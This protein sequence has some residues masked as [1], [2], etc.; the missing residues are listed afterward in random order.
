MNAQRFE[1]ARLTVAVGR[2]LI[3]FAV[4][5][6]SQAPMGAQP[7]HGSP[8]PRPSDALIRIAPRFGSAAAFSEG[9]AA[10]SVGDEKHAKWGFIDR[11]G[12]FV[13]P[14]RFDAA[15][16]FSDGL[17]AVLV[18][19]MS[20]GRWGFINRRGEFAISP[21]FNGV[22]IPGFTDRFARVMLGD[23]P[24]ARTALIDLSGRVVFPPS[25]DYIGDFVDGLANVGDYASSSRHQQTA[26]FI[27][28]HG[29]YIIGPSFYDAGP[30]REGLA[31]VTVAVGDDY[32]AGFINES[33]AIVIP[34]QFDAAKP[35]NQGYAIVGIGPIGS[36]QYG[37][38]DTQGNLRIPVQFS[39]A[40]D[41][42][43][44]MAA[45]RVG[46]D[47]SGR[48]GYIDRQGKYLINPM[49]S[50]VSSFK[51]GLAVAARED[52]KYGF[53]DKSGEFVI[54]PAF[55]SANDFHG[56]YATVAIRNG[57]TFNWGVIT[58]KGEYVVR[59]SYVAPPEFS[60]GLAVVKLNGKYGYIEQP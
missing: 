26:G 13:I 42:S 58:A 18:G 5:G 14:P 28:R 57:D 10:V 59:P 3:A 36:R 54:A 30:F 32:K 48:W 52:Q 6:C 56:K 60:E 35:F 7:T 27:N 11:N 1:L 31:E 55:D 51:E 47:S 33:G 41:F 37:Y 23:V 53:I 24:H 4:C 9:L 50:F 43:E 22:W 15:M 12:I 49:F 46:G 29:N 34:P 20:T 17:A 21:Q 8:P 2:L 25:V 19:G 16:S 44:G 45:V 40:F 38:I 39:E